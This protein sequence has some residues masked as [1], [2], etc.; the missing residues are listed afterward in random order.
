MAPP[1]GG[2]LSYLRQIWR[3]FHNGVPSDLIYG[4][5]PPDPAAPLPPDDP[6]LILPPN[7]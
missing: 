1:A 5:Q 7:P 4:P 3:E 2:Q 6:S